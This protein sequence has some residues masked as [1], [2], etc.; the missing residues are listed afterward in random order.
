VGHVRSRG[1]TTEKRIRWG[2]NLRTG[3]RMGLIVFQKGLQKGGWVSGTVG[4]SEG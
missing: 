2:V 1:Q 3:D 4:V